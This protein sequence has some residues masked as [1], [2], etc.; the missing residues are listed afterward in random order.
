MIS[1]ILLNE[2]PCVDRDLMDVVLLSQRDASSD[3][4]VFLEILEILKK[5]VVVAP[6][7]LAT[8]RQNALTAQSDVYFMVLLVS[9]FVSPGEAGEKVLDEIATAKTNPTMLRE[10]A[11]IVDAVRLFARLRRGEQVEL[12]NAAVC[13]LV[14]ALFSIP[15]SVVPRVACCA[16]FA[17]TSIVRRQNCQSLTR[18][19]R[20]TSASRRS[21]A[22]RPVSTE[23]H[24]RALIV[25]CA[26]NC[27]RTTSG[28]TRARCF[29]C[30]T[31]RR[32]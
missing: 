27:W 29:V 13:T 22:T 10:A 20:S 5:N 7:L 17:H 24:L 19:S 9:L 4:V 15:V 28:L 8:I 11:V 25:R 21:S 6:R 18:S 1:P 31:W 16:I 3:D 26:V 32:R 23:R 2:F 14:L 12:P 30:S